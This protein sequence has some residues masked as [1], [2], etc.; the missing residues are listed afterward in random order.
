MKDTLKKEDCLK[1]TE[2]G[3]GGHFYLSHRCQFRRNTLIEYKNRKYV[4]S[5]VG[6]LSGEVFANQQIGCDRYYETMA[7][8]AKF[9][10]PYWEADVSKEVEF[11]SKWSINKLEQDTDLEANQMHEDVVKELI[12]KIKS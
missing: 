5:T 1:I 11:N 6:N 12:G 10:K 8:K 3:W 4:V 2:R 9:V 7:F